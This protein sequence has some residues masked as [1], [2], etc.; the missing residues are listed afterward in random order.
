MYCLSNA[1]R[2]AMESVRLRQRFAEEH[3]LPKIYTFGPLPIPS[4]TL[5]ESAAHIFYSL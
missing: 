3:P 4:S 1:P 5:Y 2:Q